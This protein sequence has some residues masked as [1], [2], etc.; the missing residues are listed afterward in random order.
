MRSLSY[1]ISFFIKEINVANA[2][3]LHLATCRSAIEYGSEIWFPAAEDKQK[4][5]LEILQRKII[6][7]ILNVPWGTPTHYI[8]KDIGILQLQDRFKLKMEWYATRIAYNM[9]EGNPIIS[10]YKTDLGN[11][12]KSKIGT[13]NWNKSPLVKAIQKKT[14]DDA[15]FILKRDGTMLF[16]RPEN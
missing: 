5:K 4:R 16:R 9:D 3:N 14:G 7:R 1:A 13:K 10:T 12:V 2:K 6:K 11:G 15:I 8:Y